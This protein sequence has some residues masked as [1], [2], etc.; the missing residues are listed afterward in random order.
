MGSG[1]SPGQGTRLFSWSAY[2]SH[3]ARCVTEIG[4]SGTP[5]TTSIFGCD[6][7]GVVTVLESA[8]LLPVDALIEH[9]VPRI[10]LKA[11]VAMTQVILTSLS[12]QSAAIGTAF[13]GA[14]VNWCRRDQ[15]TNR[16]RL[17]RAFRSL[18]ASCVDGDQGECRGDV[19]NRDGNRLP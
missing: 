8:L 15:R 1:R 12:L 16:E 3:A 11:K 17:S 7:F 14:T 19:R 6:T 13:G 9:P 5:S 4:I 10:P 2:F 18:R